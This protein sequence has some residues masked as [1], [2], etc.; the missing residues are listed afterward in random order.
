M[1]ERVFTITPD[2]ARALNNEDYAAEFK[3]HGIDAIPTTLSEIYNIADKDKITVVFGSLSFMK[4]LF[5]EV[6]NGKNR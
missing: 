4:T 1:A 6:N 3:K 5:N 2:N